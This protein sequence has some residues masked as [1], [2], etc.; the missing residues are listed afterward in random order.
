[1]LIAFITFP[2]HVVCLIVMDSVRMFPDDI[3]MLMYTMDIKSYLSSIEV[4]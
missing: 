1:M 2:V 4:D 3:I